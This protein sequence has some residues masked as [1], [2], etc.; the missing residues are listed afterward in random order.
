[1]STHCDY[2]HKFF[3]LFRNLKKVIIYDLAEVKDLNGAVSRLKEAMPWCQF[4]MSNPLTTQKDG[5]LVNVGEWGVFPFL[6]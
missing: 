3:F 4:E 5:W 1:M 2:W 6:I